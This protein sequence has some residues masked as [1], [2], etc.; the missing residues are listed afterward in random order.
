MARKIQSI[1]DAKREILVLTAPSFVRS[2]DPEQFETLL[3]AAKSGL[4]V[5]VYLNHKPLFPI[6]HLARMR[7]CGI[8]VREGSRRWLGVD[9]S[10]EEEFWIFDRESALGGNRSQCRELEALPDPGRLSVECP[11]ARAPAKTAARYFDHRWEG[12]PESVALV[13]RHKEFSFR[14]GKGAEKDFLVYA[15]RA[16]KEISLC[17]TDARISPRLCRSLLDAMKRGVKVRI[18]SNSFGMS[19]LR[20]RLLFGRLL[21]AG[22]V[23]RFTAEHRPLETECALFDQ[24][25]IYLGALPG[26]VRSWG[27]IPRPVF[28]LHDKDLSATLSVN[29]EK[30]VGHQISSM[31]SK[32]LLTQ[33]PAPQRRT[34][35]QL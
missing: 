20:S 10:T 31:N 35:P 33:A 21:R 8:Q 23:L 25:S 29:L 4:S 13:V 34:R 32:I 7:A 6:R 18:Y 11:L 9:S 5:K 3:D 24:N 28:F 16:R 17:L 12:H 27:R 2:W 15:S 1:S 30:Q 26:S 19:R 14:G 22:A